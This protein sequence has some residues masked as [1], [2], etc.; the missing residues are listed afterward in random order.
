MWEKLGYEV[1]SSGN[2]VRASLE[3]DG[4][5]ILKSKRSHG[6]GKLDGKVPLFIRSDMKLSQPQFI[7]AYECPLQRDEYFAILRAKGLL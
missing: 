6:H 4:K 2:H 1:N 7:D 3:V 5:I